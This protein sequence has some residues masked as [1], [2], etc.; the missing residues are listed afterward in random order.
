[1]LKSLTCIMEQTLG[2]VTY[3]QNLRPIFEADP[4]LSLQWLPIN[5]PIETRI[6]K[7]PGM[8][9]NWSFRASY[10]ARRAIEAERK[11]SGRPD[12]YFFHTQVTSLLSTGLGL[13]HVP[14]IISLDATPLNYDRVGQAYGHTTGH[15][16]VEKFKFWLNKRTFQAADYL[17]T[18]SEWARQSLIED[19][20]IAGDKIETVLPGMN[21]NFWRPTQ[22]RADHPDG[23]VRLLFVG[24]D[25][26]RKG[27]KLLHEVFRRHLSEQCELHLVTKD[28]V[29]A[30]P[31]VFV[32]HNI[33]ANSP[34]L[35]QLFWQSDIFV[36]PS[37]GDCSPLANLEAMSAGLPVVSTNVGAITELV[38]EGEN[39]FV[40]TP[41][42][43]VA[44]TRVLLQL[45]AN[46]QL[47]RS[48]AAKSAARAI[49]D[50]DLSKN[51]QRILEICH[52][53]SERQGTNSFK[54]YPG[55]TTGQVTSTEEVT[56]TSNI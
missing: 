16:A 18:M 4:T 45:A 10:K 14:T 3:T 24:G 20:G 27:G 38:R 47:R 26:E 46:P 48:M 31:G 54:S 21:L 52:R 6:E 41:G 8:R 1:M 19:Y 43:E 37:A 36:L 22:P 33:K 42:D 51:G 40:I 7:L 32:H 23:K 28:Q 53:I 25:F 44:L 29:E 11:R 17:L 15:P 35:Q 56:P 13:G 34:E 5:F 30:S 49:A 2:N 12:L 50:L 9:N 39:G 55:P